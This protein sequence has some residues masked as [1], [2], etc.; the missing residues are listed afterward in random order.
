MSNYRLAIDG[1]GFEKNCWHLFLQNEFSGYETFWQR[2]IVPLTNR[3]DNIYFKTD[4]ELNKIGKTH[5][6]LC[7][8]QLHYT[9]LVHL[10]RAFVI[11]SSRDGIARDELTEGILRL[12]SALDVADEL[13]ERFPNPGTYDP[14]ADR[15]K[16]GGPPGGREA[17]SQWRAKRRKALGNKTG[18]EEQLRYYRNH[19]AHGRL[20]PSVNNRYPDIGRENDYFDWRKVT[21]RQS[22]ASLDPKHFKLPRQILASA[23]DRTLT[24]LREM[25]DQHLLAPAS[26]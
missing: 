18:P 6:D 8:A 17:R 14:W 20:H 5:H 22:F 10:H 21:E 9:V 19:L 13:L 4:Q 26:P 23:W 15:G 7:I 12:C 2:Y 1:D 16:R 11:L 3:P 25:W 24:Y